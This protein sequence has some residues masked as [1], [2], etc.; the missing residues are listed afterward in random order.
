MKK[1]SIT[2]SG[3][4]TSITLETEF[5]NALKAIAARDGLSLNALIAQI[6]E[7][8]AEYNLSSA[9]RLYILDDLQAQLQAR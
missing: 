1:H 8:R 5:W 3:H 7:N 6:D 4:P 9:V 2:I